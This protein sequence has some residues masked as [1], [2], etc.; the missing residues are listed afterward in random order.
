MICPKC[1]AEYPEEITVCPKCNVELIDSPQSIENNSTEDWVVVYTTD[2]EYEAEMLKANIE[3]AGIEVKIL[4]QK[5]QNFP[6]LGD[7]SV[8]K[9]LVRQRNVQDAISI[10]NDINSREDEK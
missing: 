5:D 6:A 8:V 1:G 3:G 4:V 7:L 2:F 10:I 9:L